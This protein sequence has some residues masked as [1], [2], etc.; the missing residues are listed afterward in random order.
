MPYGRKPHPGAGLNFA[1]GLGGSAVETADLPLH[2]S[3]FTITAEEPHHPSHDQRA[4]ENTANE[5]EY[6]YH[7]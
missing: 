5:N 3:R 2:R 1:A 6:L 7:A 4:A